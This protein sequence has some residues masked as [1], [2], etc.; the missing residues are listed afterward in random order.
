M[1]SHENL[2]QKRVALVAQGTLDTTIGITFSIKFAKLS[3]SCITL[4]NVIKIAM[5]TALLQS[6]FGNRSTA[7]KPDT[8]YATQTYKT[9][10]SKEKL[11]NRHYETKQQ[12]AILQNKAW[13]EPVQFNGE[14]KLVKSRFLTMTEKYESM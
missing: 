11:M 2:V 10:Q 6:W 14:Y 3:S 5:C 7:D 9:S 12:D 8:A 13:T 4:T 1:R